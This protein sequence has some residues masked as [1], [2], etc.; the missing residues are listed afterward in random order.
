MDG[1][2]A[3]DFTVAVEPGPGSDRRNLDPGGL[4]DVVGLAGLAAHP[5]NDVAT[6][7]PPTW[8]PAAD[9]VAPA[10]PR[11]KALA[12]LA[13][14][15]TLRLIQQADRPATPQEQ[16]TLGRWSAWGAL[17]KVFDPDEERWADIRTELD[18]LLSPTELAAA[19]RTTLNAH[20]TRPGV[21]TAMWAFVQSIGFVGGRVLEPGCGSGNFI[22]FAPDRLAIDW[23]GV[24]LD[25][26]TAQITRLLYPAATIRAEGFEQTLLPDG[27][28][29]L[30]VGNVPF[31]KVALHD[32]RHNR[33]GQSIHNHFIIK[34]LNLCRPGGLVAVLTSR[35]TLDARSDSARAQISDLADLVTAVRL[36]SSTHMA[37]AGTQAVT[38]LIV[39]R[40]R[41]PAAERSNAGDWQRA[42]D[43]DT[44]DG[45]VRVNEWFADHP[46]LM[47]GE[48]RLGG[49]YRGDDLRIVAEFDTDRLRTT[50]DDQSRAARRRGHL[51]KPN[52][53]ETTEAAIVDPMATVDPRRTKPG[54][55]IALEGNQFGRFVGGQVEPIAVPKSAC[56]ELRSLCGLRDV[57]AELLD[58][59]AETLAD[60]RV[61]ELQGTL[62]RRYDAYVGR[63][64]PLNR[65]TWGRTGRT[66]DDG[67]EIMRRLRPKMGGFRDDP[68][69][70]SV[71]ALEE[72]DPGSQTAT[73]TA[74][75]TRRLLAPREVRESTDDPAEA[76]LICLDQVGRVDLGRI[77]GLLGTDETGARVRLAELVYDD[78]LTGRLEPA[79]SYLAGDVRSKLAAAGE[80]TAREERF[81]VNVDALTAVVPVDLTPGE[82]DVRPGQSWIPTDVM[83]DFVIDVLES[84][85]VSVAHDPLTATWEID[86]SSWQRSSVVMTSEWGTERKDAVT[87]LQA[88]ANNSTVT[89]WDQL[90]DTRVVNQQATLDAREKQAALVE[91]FAG[92]VW[93]EPDRAS[94]LAAIYNERFNSHVPRS[95]DGSHL[96]LPGLAA[97]FEPRS[98]QRAAVARVLA[99][100]T[101]LLAHEVGAGKTAT[102]V[103]ASM[104][105]RRLGLVNKPMVVVPNHMLEQFC[106]EWRALYPAAKVLF[107]TAAEQGPAGR[108]L[109]V[110]RA[111]VGEWDAVVVT[112]SVFERIP[113]APVTEARFIRRQVDELR[114]ASTTFQTS[115]GRRSRTVKDIEMR[116]LRLEERHKTLLNRADKDDGATFEQLGVDY[117]FVDEAHHAKNLGISTRM[118]GLGK[119]GSGYASQLDI[120][121]E[122]LRERYGPK[123]LTLSTATPIANSLSEMWVMQHYARPDRLDAAGVGPFDAW[124]SNF[125]GQVT[126]LELAPEGT[127]YRIATRLAKFRNVPDLIAMFTEFADVRTK[128]DLDLPRPELVNGCAE[129]VVVPGDDQLRGFVAELGERAEQVRNRSVRPEDDN[130]LKISS[131]GRAAALDVRLVGFRRPI[132]S[133]KV[134]VAAARIATIWEANRDGRFT[135]PGGNEHHRPG[136]LQLVFAEL[137]TPGGARWGLYEQLRNELADRGVPRETVRFMHEARNPREKEQLFNAARNGAVAVLVGTTEKMGVGTNVQARCVALHH[138]DCPWRPADVEQREGRILRQGNQNPTVEILRYVTEGSFD[139]YMWQTVE[140]KAGFINQVLAGRHGGRTLDDVTSEQE[141]SYAEVKALATGDDRIVRKAGL[142]ADVTRMRRQRTAHF[143][144]QSRL[145]RTVTTGL[146]RLG[147]NDRYAT[148]LGSLAEQLTST[149]GDHFAVTVDGQRHTTRADGGNA[150]IDL[151]SSTMKS[152]RAGEGTDRHAI[153]IGGLDLTIRCDAR[154]PGVVDITVPTTQ[155]R[156]TVERDDLRDVDPSRLSQRL[157]RLVARVPD[158]LADVATSSAE[159]RTQVD[160]AQRRLGVAFPHEDG[161]RRLQTELDDLTAELAERTSSGDGREQPPDDSTG[162]TI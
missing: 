59:Q 156:L 137:G 41:S 99:E 73:K 54:S 86:V 19:R 78:P 93:E 109:F 121:L 34:S 114:A 14:L 88:A 151:L 51:H 108:K 100:P 13:A 12:N 120:R 143:Q 146:E 111:A 3:L 98:H 89:V 115:M 152:A 45:P 21:V 123:V 119:R 85:P 106:T 79:P 138:L 142:E 50:L 126:R 53:P 96:T 80:A 101:T 107:P 46:E 56:H 77:A 132:G 117:L 39:F 81:R 134:S 75:F 5:P 118:T 47:L 157:E 22:G 82:I 135:D 67:E 27:C 63:Y 105:L 112:E 48:P 110:A 155:L 102:M 55:L 84:P 33:S 15:R 49:Q 65:F 17:P 76:V 136:A 24:E 42:V 1:T 103:M 31:G 131:D 139:V 8:R 72:F 124:A 4:A 38:D 28:A 25:Q 141:L 68:D 150:A 30:V 10:G 6:L 20:Y 133:T 57:L 11:T 62:S 148:V 154:M 113:L 127:H 159:V 153:I 40:R 52:R 58:V 87:L 61:A 147:R 125:A 16:D 69:A 71:F 116:A 160:A 37:V 91:R 2:F 158:E 83:S 70:P 60:G 140:L 35:F 18:H 7:P 94:C 44:I 104:E 97:D 90:D 66:G 74:V 162:R 23:T 161:L 122:W 129:T 145:Q 144:D 32:P 149:R 95:Y 64:G 128:S 36:P 130:M 29:D 43:F 92:W 26:V 9:S